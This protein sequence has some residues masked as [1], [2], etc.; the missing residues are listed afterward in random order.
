MKIFFNRF[1]NFN[2]CQ[3]Q[4]LEHG[5][6]TVNMSKY[7]REEINLHLTRARRN[8]ETCKAMTKGYVAYGSQN[9]EPEALP[10][11]IVCPGHGKDPYES[12]M[13]M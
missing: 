13:A 6:I 5:K 4:Q 10:G 8:K 7:V 1:N 9:A 3:R 11:E 2:G 12:Y